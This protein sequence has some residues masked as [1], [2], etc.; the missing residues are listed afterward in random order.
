MKIDTNEE[1]FTSDKVAAAAGCS[2]A[3]L[4]QWR[5]RYEFLENTV[6][7]GMEVKRFSLSDICVVRAIKVLTDY[8]L[9]AR[10]AISLANHPMG[11][12]R[13]FAAFLSKSH[14]VQT[15]LSIRSSKS[16]NKTF[17]FSLFG[18]EH[19][20]YEMERSGG[21]MTVLDL[22]VIAEHVFNHFEQQNKK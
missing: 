2:E 21:V 6:T 11:L 22:T 14:R 10:D 16:K 9:S 20:Y 19:F 12:R 15:L 5:N 1:V 3:T 4:R 7:G 17:E 18:P 8:G 13:L